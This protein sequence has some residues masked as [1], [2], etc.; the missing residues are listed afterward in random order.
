MAIIKLEE[1]DKKNY[2]LS[3]QFSIVKVLFKYYNMEG[4][5]QAH[6]L[7]YIHISYVW[8]GGGGYLT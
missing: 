6:I 2:V 3:L 5:G 8:V 4:F 7:K 1:F